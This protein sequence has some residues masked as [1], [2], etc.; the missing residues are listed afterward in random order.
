MTCLKNK[1]RKGMTLIE[2]IAALAIIPIVFAAIFQVTLSMYKTLKTLS[3]VSDV[4]EKTKTVMIDITHSLKKCRKYL[5][6]SDANSDANLKDALN[7]AGISLGPHDKIAL[8][9]EGYDNDNSRFMYVV[10][11]N[12]LYKYTFRN[13]VTLSHYTEAQLPGGGYAEY[14]IDKAEYDK[15]NITDPS[16]PD[17][18]YNWVH[19]EDDKGNNIYTLSGDPGLTFIEQPFI[20]YDN[21]ENKY[22]LYGRENETDYYKFELVPVTDSD[23]KL[24][25]PGKKINYIKDLNVTPDP[26]NGNNCKVQ[27]DAEKNGKKKS[28]K[29][30]V[31]VP[32]G[33]EG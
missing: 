20:S 31:Y 8:Y 30:D 15:K 4:Q 17:Y 6:T 22:Y 21:Y 18:N 5:N 23:T 26:Q 12:E 27:I 28:I 16:S 14:A 9:I 10:R 33:S 32:L 29:A 7:N 25:V 3:D 13:G 2:L 11:N 1:K 19:S 24:I